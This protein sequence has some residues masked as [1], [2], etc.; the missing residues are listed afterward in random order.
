MDNKFSLT[1]CGRRNHREQIDWPIV[2]KSEKAVRVETP[3]GEVWLPLWKFGQKT[4]GCDSVPRLLSVLEELTMSNSDA[5]VRVWKAGRGKT[6]ASHKFRIVV[7]IDGEP[8]V[9]R[10]RTLILPISQVKVVAGKSMAPLWLLRKKIESRE[11]LPRAQWAG[12]KAVRAQIL[13][14]VEKV[15]AL[16]GEAAAASQRRLEAQQA[17]KVELA[18]KTAE[19]VRDI[20]DEGEA[21]LVFC[22]AKFSREDLAELGCKIDWWP[23]WSGAAASD[24]SHVQKIRALVEVARA[25]PGFA[26]WK[27]KNK[28]KFG[29]G[30]AAA[31]TKV[32][33]PDRILENC[34]VD[35]VEWGGTSKQRIKVSRSAE[36]C[37][38]RFF[39]KKREIVT[40]GGAVLVKMCGPNLQING[41]SDF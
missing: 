4:Y 33:Q 39:G 24:F 37:T 1:I 7:A 34:Q 10:R 17:E 14:A 22:Q 21:A 6:A 38:V 27:E 28:T 36:N 26:K 8:P 31:V 16:D 5:L 12:M 2:A 29:E 23:S 41:E 32:G 35:W 13:A 18:S 9:L 3:G 30:K 20:G 25:N 40:P 19:M 11:S 15:Q